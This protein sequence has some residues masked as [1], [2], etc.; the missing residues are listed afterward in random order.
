[1]IVKPRGGKW[2][3][4]GQSA[5]SRQ[6]AA[7]GVSPRGGKRNGEGGKSLADDSIYR[8]KRERER[9]AKPGPPV[10]DGE[11]VVTETVETWSSAPSHVP[12]QTHVLALSV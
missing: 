5:A 4:L 12:G 8:G 2:K 6:Q 3:W 9:A 11:P 10:G 7:G 1:M